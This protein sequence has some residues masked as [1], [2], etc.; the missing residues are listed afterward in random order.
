ME[1]MTV[2]HRYRIF[3]HLARESGVRDR[4]MASGDDREVFLARHVKER[5]T[6]IPYRKLLKRIEVRETA[7]DGH[8]LL[9]LSDPSHSSG[10]GLLYLYGGAFLNPP[11]DADFRLARTLVQKTGADVYFPLYPL[12]PEAMIHE[13]T[14]FIIAAMNMMG[15]RYEPDRTAAIGFSSGACLALYA[16]MVQKQEGEFCRYPSRLILNSPIMRIPASE[17]E[18]AVMKRLDTLDAVL[19]A[20]FLFADGMS[21]LMLEKEEERFRYLADPLSFDLQGLPETDIYTGTHEIAYAYLL[22]TVQKLKEDGVTVNVHT[23]EGLMHCWGLYPGYPEAEAAQREYEEIINR[24]K[25]DS[26]K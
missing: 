5:T 3:E 9:I 15:Q 13:I 6:E 1:R 2:S 17:Q 25:K 10:I 22:E 16:Y 8:K 12:F 20:V 14:E 4:L 23:G 18:M 11:K 7:L 19:P 26:V 21:G 24:L